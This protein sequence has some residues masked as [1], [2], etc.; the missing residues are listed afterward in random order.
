MPSQK[1]TLPDLVAREPKRARGKLRVAAL[2]DSGAAVFA[3][4]GFDGATMTEIAARASTAIG[5]IY[6]FFPSKEALADALLIRYAARLGEGLQA[7]ED[8]AA[9]LNETTLTDALIDLMLELRADRASAIASLEAREGG[10]DRAAS[11]RSG[12]RTGTRRRVAACL[13]AAFHLAPERAAAMAPTLLQV[14][15]AIPALAAEDETTGSTL[16]TEA[17]VMLSCYLRHGRGQ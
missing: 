15:K 4:K 10:K 5:S 16:V 7:I 17:R 6:Q 3:E 2:L 12:L 13:T 14:L 11:G 8:R 9:S 1:S